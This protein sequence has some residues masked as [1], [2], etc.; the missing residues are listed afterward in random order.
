MR[1]RRRSPRIFASVAAHAVVGRA[2]SGAT[3]MPRDPASSPFPGVGASREDDAACGSA[4]T[5]TSC[6][7]PGPAWASTS[8][9]CW[10]PSTPA[11]P[12]TSSTA[13]WCRASPASSLLGQRLSPRAGH[14]RLGPL[15]TALHGDRDERR[16][17]PP[18]GAARKA[19]VG[20]SRH[21]AGWPPRQD[22][23][24]ALAVLDQPA[25]VTLAHRRHRP[26]RHPARAAR[27][28]RCW[29][30]SGSTSGW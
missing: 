20:A 24:A 15:T 13:C 10:P 5:A 29:P 17:A 30:A 19:L 22:R 16:A 6:A 26:R 11:R 12:A 25:L 14:R 27:S 7:S 4:S 21:R 3:F 9:T 18:A 28:T 23:P 2:S 1:P 8:P